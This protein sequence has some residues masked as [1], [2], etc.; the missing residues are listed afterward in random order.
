MFVEDMYDSDSELELL[1]LLSS[2]LLMNETFLFFFLVLDALALS[3][4]AIC[5]IWSAV[6]IR[7]VGGA[8]GSFVLIKGP[9]SNPHLVLDAI[10]HNGH[11]LCP[12]S[13][14]LY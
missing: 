11:R 12:F 10:C 4:F 9:A 2:T 3:A 5:S 6:N 1:S 13:S 14:L 7:S 8:L